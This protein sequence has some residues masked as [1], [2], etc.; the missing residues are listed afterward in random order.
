MKAPRLSALDSPKILAIASAMVVSLAGCSAPGAS[1]QVQAPLEPASIVSPKASSERTA[2]PPT[3]VSLACRAIPEEETALYPPQTS[4]DPLATSAG[5]NSGA[6]TVV[7]AAEQAEFVIVGRYVGLER[8]GAYGAPGEDVG[9]YAVAQ[10]H[11]DRVIAG[12]A[13]IS[14]GTLRVPFL[15]AMGGGVA[16]TLSR[17]SASARS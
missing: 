1:E 8:G 14:G 2:S 16:P 3:A 5:N 11:V 6:T 10:I 12:D 7:E 13:T 9:W 17:S 4:W 15:L